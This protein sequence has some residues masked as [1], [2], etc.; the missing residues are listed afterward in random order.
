L[1]VGVAYGT[2]ARRVREILFDILRKHPV[3]LDDPKPLVTFEQFGDSSLN[4]VIRAY[5]SSM[6]ARLE[7]TNELHTQIHERFAAENIEI[8]FPQRDLHVRSIQD[9]VKMKADEGESE[10]EKPSK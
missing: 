9:A 4:F 3:I 8:P 1:T 5:L 10:S 6:D 7:T 2:D